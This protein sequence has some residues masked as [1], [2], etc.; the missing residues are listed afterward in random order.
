MAPPP[1]PTKAPQCQFCLKRV[2]GETELQRYIDKN[3]EVISNIED[4]LKLLRKFNDEQDESQELAPLQFVRTVVATPDELADGASEPRRQLAALGGHVY[5][6]RAFQVA[7][8]KR[9]S[10]EGHYAPPQLE[11]SC[12]GY[13]ENAAICIRLCAEMG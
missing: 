9:S 1:T 12:I 6:Y 3:F 13:A 7:T 5:L 10:N 8:Q 4:S 11:V 2:E